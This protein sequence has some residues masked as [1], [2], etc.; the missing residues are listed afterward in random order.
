MIL[1]LLLIK[2][3][4]KLEYPNTGDF[5][6]VDKGSIEDKDQVSIMDCRMG[7]AASQARK[8]AS[9]LLMCVQCTQL[10]NTYCVWRIE[11]KLHVVHNLRKYVRMNFLWGG[12][13]HSVISKYR[14][15]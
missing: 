3:P 2:K 14:H 12:C 11:G 8:L 7:Y 6:Q 13:L 10:L 15:F 1:K 9:V 5:L 4:Q